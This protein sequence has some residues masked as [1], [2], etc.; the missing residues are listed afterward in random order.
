MTPYKYLELSSCVIVPVFPCKLAI[1]RTLMC[2]TTYS[3][4]HHVTTL[5]QQLLVYYVQNN[6]KNEWKLAD[7]V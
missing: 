3:R 5:V 7:S 6:T 4:A 2:N 1:L